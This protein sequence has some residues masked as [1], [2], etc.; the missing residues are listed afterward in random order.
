MRLQTRRI[1]FPASINDKGELSGKHV[2]LQL[3]SGDSY[4][5]TRKADG[6]EIFDIK[7]PRLAEQ[8]QQQDASPVMLVMRT[9]DGQIRWMNVTDYL[10]RHGT[11]TRQIIFDGESFTALSV[12]KLRDKLFSV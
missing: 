6:K 3:K 7:H 12:I 1:K 11:K 2:Y 5:Q 9:S 4:T 10:N 8:W